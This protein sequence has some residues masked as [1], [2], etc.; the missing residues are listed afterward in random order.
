MRLQQRATCESVTRFNRP[1]LIAP[2]KRMEFDF[3][4]PSLSEQ[5]L[6]RLLARAWKTFPESYFKQPLMRAA[7]EASRMTEQSGFALLLL[8]ELFAELAVREMLRAE[9]LRLGRI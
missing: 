9:Y 3:A 1:S 8:P 2:L 4:Q 7:K 6:G 5:L